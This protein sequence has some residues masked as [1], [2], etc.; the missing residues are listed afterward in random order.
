LTMFRNLSDRRRRPGCASATPM[1]WRIS[2]AAGPSAAIAEGDGAF[3]LDAGGG[4]VAPPWAGLPLGRRVP[5]P[6]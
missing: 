6:T 3:L 4:P 5:F 1:T 2:L